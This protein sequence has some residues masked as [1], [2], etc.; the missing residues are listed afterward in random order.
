MRRVVDACD[1]H[2]G[3]L[4]RHGVT[5]AASDY[6]G[7]LVR[8]AYET[9]LRRGNLFLLEQVNVSNSG[10]VYVTHEKTGQPH[11]CSIQPATVQRLRKL[12]GRCPLNWADN[13]SFYRR[14]REICAAAGV[15]G[16][17][18]QRVRKTAATQIWLE[19][20]DSPARVQAFLGHLTGDM[21]RHYVDTSQ[22]ERRPPS[23]PAL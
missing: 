14:W 16:G 8:V 12:P 15:P 17:G 13:R 10:V 5:L 19:N 4:R 20:P 3:K 21:W 2:P 6:F 22:G 7:G 1:D 11:V 18:L 9:G 23:P